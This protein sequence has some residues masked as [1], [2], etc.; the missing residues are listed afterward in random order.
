VLSHRV[1][2]PGRRAEGVG[3]MKP[4]TGGPVYSLHGASGSGCATAGAQ[5]SAARRRPLPRKRRG[6]L[7]HRSAREHPVKGA[8]RRAP[9]P[10]W[11]T[12]QAVWG[13][14]PVRRRRPPGTP[15]EGHS[16]RFPARPRRRSRSGREPPGSVRR[17]SPRWVPGVDR[18]PGTS[19][20]L[21][22]SGFGQRPHC[23]S[24]GDHDQA[25]GGARI[26]G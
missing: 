17:F 1:F 24:G 21:L 12:P 14:P 7:T 4:V 2:P 3:W 13:A 16:R 26:V 5:A 25:P 22:C 20:F 15:P 19:A 11:A 8:D 18:V 6:K 9:R 10:G 23:R